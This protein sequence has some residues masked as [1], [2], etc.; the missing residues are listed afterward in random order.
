MKKIV[1]LLALISYSAFNAQCA[2]PVITNFECSPPSYT[3]FGALT[4]VIN[5]FSEDINT[6]ANVG[7]Y[8]DDGTAAFDNLTF[9]K[10]AAIDFSTNNI[11]KFK[12]YSTKLVPLVVKLEGGAT[13]TP[14]E[15]PITIDVTGSWVEYTVDL[16]SQSAEDHQKIVFFFNFN[17][18]DGTATDI[19]YLDD[20]RWEAATTSTDPIVTD[21]ESTKPSQGGFPNNKLTIVSNHVSSGINTTASIGK[22]KDDGTNGFDGLIFDYGSA[23]NLATNNILKIKLYT[24]TSIQILAKLE[25]GSTA[26]E[27]FSPFS[28]DNGPVNSWIEFTFDFSAYANNASG[29]DGNTKI[30]LFV[31]AAVTSGTPSDIYY[32]DDIIW[33]NKTTWTGTASTDWSSPGNW[34]GGVPSA[35]SEVVIPDVANDPI[36]GEFTSTGAVTGNITTNNVLTIA[37]GSS[38]IVN[39]IATGEVT[40]KRNLI[41]PALTGDAAAD[42]LA[43]WHLVG[44]PVNGQ[45]YNNSYANTNIIATSGTKRGIATYNNALASGNWSYL[46][47]NDSNSGTFA[48]AT[49]YTMKTTMSSDVSFTGTVNTVGVDKGITVGAGT[50]F[51]LLSNPF[52]SY[53]NSGSFLNL[54]A[55]SDKLTSKTIWVWNSSTKNYDAKVSGDAFKLAPGQGFFV[56]SSATGDVTFEKSIQS[57]E[58][59]GIFLRSEPKPKVELNITDG[60]L[61]RYAKIYYNALATKGFDN[62]FDGETFGGAKNKFD[63]FTQLLEN[64]LGKNYQIQALPN[65]NLESNIIPVG[66]KAEAGKEITFSVKALS[67]PSNIKVFLEDRITN[68]FTRLDEDNSNYKV[69]LSNNLNGIGRFYVH[70]T[71]SALSVANVT[72]ES[73]S[74]YKSDASNLRI[75]GLPKGNTSIKLFNILG[76]QIMNS[77]FESNGVKDITLPKT[78]N[79]IYIVQLF[80]EAGQLNKKIILE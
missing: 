73:I 7:Q 58:S 24:P 48:T 15:T 61:N 38:L 55:N 69:T 41:T 74:I 36:I 32:L 21:F 14:L 49:G 12:I 42:K 17:K 72:L 25:G 8:T 46:E 33:T 76:K 56:S 19:Y 11:L 60:T 64:N 66:I 5:P 28:I 22:Y 9:D 37:S 75:V 51:N 65:T 71:Q 52:T 77:S 1:L 40:Y 16:S 80:T 67:L 44:S 10:G 79:G 13:S 45:A 43:G 29:G 27:I 50:P 4:S 6:S 23:I 57:H 26:R 39:G 35:T 3:S 2:D 31:N 18:T 54:T 70:T 34:N 47:N 78:A 68:T 63:V 20:I 59:T 30:V 62:G 53:I